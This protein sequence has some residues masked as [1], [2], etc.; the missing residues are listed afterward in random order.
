GDNVS[1]FNSLQAALTT[2]G[3]QAGNVIQIEQGATPG[4]LTD[5]M[6]PNLKNITIQG[7]SHT[8]AKDF[9]A[10][11]KVND[12]LTITTPQEGFTFRNVRLSLEGGGIT[13]SEA[14][15]A[16]RDCD[17]RSTHAGVH[18]D[19]VFNHTTAAVLANTTLI[20]EAPKGSSTC[21]VHVYAVPGSH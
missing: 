9:L 14:N 7:N 4:A 11:V 15:G 10:P 21:L 20:R 6:L 5:A 12:N 18:D 3:L 8:Q 1:K 17:I 13:S 16:I 19:I 2:P